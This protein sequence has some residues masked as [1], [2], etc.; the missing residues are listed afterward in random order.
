MFE[1]DPLADCWNCGRCDPTIEIFVKSIGR[2]RKVCSE[3]CREEIEELE[4]KKT[5]K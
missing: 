2:M 4:K 5:S 3:E 1:P